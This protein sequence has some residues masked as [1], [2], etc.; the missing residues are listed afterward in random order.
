MSKDRTGREERCQRRE[1]RERTGEKELT[2]VERRWGISRWLGRRDHPTE[3]PRH[4]EKAGGACV[5]GGGSRGRWMTLPY[6]MQGLSPNQ[7]LTERR[8]HKSRVRT[9]HWCPQPL[10]LP[11]PQPWP[12]ASARMGPQEMLRLKHLRPSPRSTRHQQTVGGGQQPCHNL[13]GLEAA[14]PTPYKTVCLPW[15][16]VPP[17]GAPA[18]YLQGTEAAVQIIQPRGKDELLIGPT[19]DLERQD[20]QLDFGSCAMTHRVL[21]APQGL[22][23]SEPLWLLVQC[24]PDPWLRAL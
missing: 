5:W 22:S 20:T 3:L 18:R 7:R 24:L 4:R 19:Q 6:G 1:G 14:P 16:C 10:S 2:T 12:K 13:L 15:W 9:R 21:P 23:L 8:S 11:P 17:G